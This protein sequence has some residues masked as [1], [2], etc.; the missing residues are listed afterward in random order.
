MNKFI[1]AFDGFNFAHTNCEFAVAFAK[2][3]KA[4]LTGIFLD[5]KTYT[6]YKIYDLVIEEGV[7]ESKLK[8]LKQEDQELRIITSKKFGEIC[9]NARIEYNIHHDHEIAVQGLLHE[10]IFADLLFINKNEKFVHHEEKFPSRFIKDVLSHTQ[11]PVLITPEKFVGT[12]K[13]IFLYDGEP[14][15]V[16]AI[17]MFSYLFSSLRELP[18]EIIMTKKMEENLHIPDHKLLKEFLKRHFN[19]TIYTV[20]KGIPEE[21]IVSHLKLENKNFITVL[22]AYRRTM[23]SRW[24]HSS[25][26]D[27]LIKNFNMPVFIAHNK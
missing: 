18:V 22:G 26:A 15:S 27:A 6:S 24:F 21:E 7:S 3:E 25:L 11:C 17:R 5:D 9:E 12:E 10:T 8:K 2:L 14:N 4:H 20:L 16:Y 19:N 13:L 23:V 1:A